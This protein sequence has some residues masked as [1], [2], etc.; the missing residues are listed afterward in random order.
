MTRDEIYRHLT[1][2]RRATESLYSTFA[3]WWAG[4]CISIIPTGI[5]PLKWA[6]VDNPWP[7]VL[8]LLGAA[9][10]HAT[11][12]H[13]NGKWRMSPG[14]RAIGLG[15]MALVFGWL[16]ARGYPQ[17]T[18]FPTYATVAGLYLLACKGAIADLRF[19]VSFHA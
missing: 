5:N 16:A 2:K 14:L 15:V 6:G 18:A 7:V 9:I 17:S 10:I 12:I 13:V 4:W 1:K 19:T 3:L 8:S 11:G